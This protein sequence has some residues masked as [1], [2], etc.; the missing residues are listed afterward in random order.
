M[1]RTSTYIT[2]GGRKG[3]KEEGRERRREEGREPGLREE[4]GTLFGRHAIAQRLGSSC[5][6]PCIH[7]CASHVREGDSY[8]ER[9]GGRGRKCVGERGGG[10]EGER[11]EEEEN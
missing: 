5:I 7:V 1:R 10:M 3:G 9:L 11:E 4:G 6:S 2:L 8:F